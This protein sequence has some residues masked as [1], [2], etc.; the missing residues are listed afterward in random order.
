MSQ[1]SLTLKMK[2]K[3]YSKNYTTTPFTMAECRCVKRKIVNEKAAEPDGIPGAIL[4]YVVFRS[5][6]KIAI[7]QTK[8]KYYISRYIIF[9]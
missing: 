2:S 7:F 4:N 6:F 3:L 8:N 5:I 9:T 1:E